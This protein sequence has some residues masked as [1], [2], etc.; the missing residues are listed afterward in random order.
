MATHV[1][2]WWVGYFLA[3]PF[4]RL[5]HNP[6]KILGA[7]VT[8]GMT[9]L[10]VGPAMGFFTL[11]MA[12]LVGPTGTVVCV[13][14]QARMLRSL[15]RRAR[16]AGLADRIIPRVCQPASLGVDDFAGR[17]E[18]VLAFAVTHEM[19][20]AP[21]FFAG[22]RSAMKPGAACL[23]AEPKGHVSVRGFDATLALAAQ[24]GLGVVGRPGILRCRVAVLKK[25]E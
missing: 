25:G 7:F 1:C 3:S 12:R 6:D 19:P 24:H 9:V 20:D 21:A 15:V 23:V 4:R 2:P 8:R 5:L 13:D 18:F 16:A 14:L 10:D 11:P 22:V 17:I